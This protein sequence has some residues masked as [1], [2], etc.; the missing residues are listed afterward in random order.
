MTLDYEDIIKEM[1]EDPENRNTIYV[2][3]FMKHV[4]ENFL[5]QQFGHFKE[6]KAI[7]A[8]KN[9]RSQQNEKYCFISKQLVASN[10]VKFKVFGLKN[11]TDAF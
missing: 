2:S 8:P 1:E 7:F 3:G 6:I 11:E 9:Q 4:T 5:Q 10:K